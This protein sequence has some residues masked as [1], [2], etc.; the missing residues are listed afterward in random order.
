MNWRG[1]LTSRARLARNRLRGRGRWRVLTGL[2]LFG[3][4]FV[5]VWGA[6]TATFAHFRS[7]GIETSASEALLALVLSAALVG[8][9]VFDLQVVVSA[10]LLDSD[11]ELL[12]RA[13]LSP[14]QLLTIKTIDSLPRTASLIAAVALP[15]CLA[16]GVAGGLP[17]WGFG[18]LPILLAGL[19]AAPLG[20]GVASALLLLHVLPAR[21]VREV[22]A[23][24]STIVLLGLW[25]LNSFVMPRWL[26]AEDVSAPQLFERLAPAPWVVEWSPAHWATNALSAARR[27]APLEAV[28]WT[29]RLV[30]TGVASLGVAG[31]V[32]RRRLEDVLGKVAA[33]EARSRRIARPRRAPA[34]GVWALLLK[35]ARLFTR[36]WAVLGDVITAGLLWTLLPWI[37]GPVHQAPPAMLARFMLIALAVGLGYEV[38]A[39]TLPYEGAA[40]AW[41]RLAPVSPWRW[42]IAKW[43]GAALV[44]L[45]LLLIAAAAVRIALPLDW[46][47]WFEVVT[48][49]LS[50]LALA[51]VLGLWMGWAFGD[52][53]WT[54]P[55]AMLTLTGRLLASAL[56]IGQAAVWLVG[57]ALCDA[58]RGSLPQGTMVWAPLA[59]AAL[60]SFP[61]L[62]L[63]VRTAKR[64]EWSD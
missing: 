61:A 10:V 46:S 63:V 62:A 32:A 34:V 39:R 47:V 60:L 42:N 54:N 28:A 52:P 6:L 19:W 5:L 30:V 21:R 38:G 55:R 44:S 26:D 59:F 50:A 40:L 9:L 31:W 57:L 1:L 35:D 12:R 11:L 20:V 17:P 41:S 14:G 22:L 58:L 3:W 36:D 29:L 23:V 18:L 7:I 49:A 33:S 37:A 25:M 51:I 56:L 2:A 64:H 27:G 4:F 13:P 8:V 43:I 16:F 53:A 45:P 15:A 24:F 48:A